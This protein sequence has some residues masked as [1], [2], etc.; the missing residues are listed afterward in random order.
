V[1]EGS[2]EWQAEQEDSDGEWETDSGD[3]SDA[4]LDGTTPPLAAVA[5]ASASAGMSEGME[6]DLLH[7]QQQQQEPMDAGYL[8]VFLLKY[9]CPQEG[10]YGTMAAVQGSSSGACEC[11]VCGVVRTEAEFM[12]ELGQQQ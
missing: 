6:E 3:G 8:S 10:C 7:P 4:D 9:M 2:P 11:S 12:A 5:A 1:L